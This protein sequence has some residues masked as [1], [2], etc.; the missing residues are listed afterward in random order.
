MDDVVTTAMAGEMSEHTQ[1]EHQRGHHA[2]APIPRVE[3]HPWAGSHDPNTRDVGLGTSLPLAQGHDRDIVAGLGKPLGQVA[4]PALRP[5]DGV[6]E[7]AVV[8]DT[9]A[10]GHI[11]PG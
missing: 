7:K 6:R 8:D 10:Y 5:P 3:L 4:I 11:L 9:N 1:T 2:P